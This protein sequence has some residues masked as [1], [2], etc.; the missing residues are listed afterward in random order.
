MGRPLSR[1]EAPQ[2]GSQDLEGKGELYMGSVSWNLKNMRVYLPEHK[3]YW[4]V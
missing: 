1:G 3:G 4:S 2:G